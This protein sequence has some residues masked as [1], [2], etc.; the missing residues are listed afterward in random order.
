MIPECTLLRLHLQHK[1]ILQLIEEMTDEDL[2]KPFIAGKWSVFDNV[3]HLAVYQHTFIKRIKTI[4]EE[5]EPRFERYV[6]ENDPLF[7][8]QRKLTFGEVWNDLL[9]AREEIE[10][11]LLKLSMQDLQK[12]GLHPGYGK[13]NVLQWTEFFLLH[14]AH[15]LYTIFGLC[16]E[17]RKLKQ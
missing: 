15:H 6:A 4:V 13:M 5:N 11:G 1:V 3:V 10:K 8:I 2:N 12:T 9:E 17:W 7:E 16:G 14:E